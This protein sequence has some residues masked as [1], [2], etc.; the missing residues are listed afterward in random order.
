MNIVEV[1]I[2]EYDFFLKSESNTSFTQ[3]SKWGAFKTNHNWKQ[4]LLGLYSSGELLGVAQILYKKVPGS[5]YKLAYCSGGYNLIDAEH[6]QIFN[7]K[8]AFYLKN[9]NCFVLKIDPYKQIERIEQYN[10]A[11]PS[12]KCELGCIKNYKKLGY[13]H[14]GFYNQ[15][16]GMQPRHTFRINT[17]NDYNQVLER[18]SSHTKRN[19]KLA[20]KYDATEVIS[21][22]IEL[23]PQFYELLEITAKRDK[24]S[25]REYDYFK[26]LIGTLGDNIVLS[27]VKLDT[28]KLERELNNVSEVLNKQ[29]TMQQN[30]QNLNIK[31]IADL[32]K[33]LEANQSRLEEVLSYTQLSLNE[34]FIAGNLSI[35]DGKN[36]WY[37][38][39]AS[40]DD[41]K[42][43]K[44]A[45]KLMNE[46]VNYCIESNLSY[47][48]LY[49]V[50]GIFDK[51]HPD[52]G[53][54]AFKSGFGGDLIEYIGEFDKPINYPIYIGF[55]K[56]YPKL[57]K[58]RK[59]RA[60]K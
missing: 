2:E 51:E 13:K 56:V 60:R 19:I 58:L 44:P 57:K 28:N 21:G 39:G 55:N 1:G 40:S 17:E 31:H 49:G 25:I 59:A 48:D 43:L 52:Y 29:I 53:L 54:Y 22:G 41:F 16:E 7:R 46:M 18:M 23:L 5:K 20:D 10:F 50:S 27:L 8:L 12:T 38:Y 15:F 3:M 14:L 26:S 33:Q 37:L 36:C 11:K 30:K 9:K 34:S 6:E 35:T 24:F 45:Y 32:K 42:F 4:E 47:Y